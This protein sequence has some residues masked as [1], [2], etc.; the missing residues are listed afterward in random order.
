MNEHEYILATDIRTLGCA[1]AILRNIVPDNNSY[2]D[3]AEYNK[4]MTLL[5]R[6]QQMSE[7]DLQRSNK[8]V[9]NSCINY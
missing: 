8:S 1:I 7:R 3:K 6:W 9:I 5:S 4:I 2:I